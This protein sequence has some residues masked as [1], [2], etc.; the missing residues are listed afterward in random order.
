[1]GKTPNIKIGRTETE[2]KNKAKHSTALQ[3]NVPHQVTL[4]AKDAIEMKGVQ[5]QVTAMS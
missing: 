2:R 1:M 4:P 5:G 3:Y